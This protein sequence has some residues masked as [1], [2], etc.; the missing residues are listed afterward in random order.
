MFEPKTKDPFA[1]FAAWFADAEASE[2]KDPNAMTVATADA[3]G[4]PSARILLLKEVDERGFVFYTNFESRKGAELTVNPF[5]ALC[6]HWKASGRQVRVE[7]PTLRVSDADA[8]EYFRSRARLSQIGAWASQQSRPL[9][10]RDALMAMVSRYEAE[11]ADRE[12]PRP[13]YWTGTRVVP[14][15][16]E[17]WQDGDFRLHDRFVFSRARESDAWTVTRLSP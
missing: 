8:D 9:A 17:F 1:L 11:Y 4:R 3:A 10:D 14:L 7:G 13:P 16:I 2:S 12:I 6:F 15:H 5:A